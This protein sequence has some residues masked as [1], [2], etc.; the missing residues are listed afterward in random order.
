MEA[1]H[2]RIYRKSLKLYEDLSTCARLHVA[3]LLVKDGRILS[4]GYNGVPSGDHHC[5]DTFIQMDGK[6]YIGPF[7]PPDEFERSR[8]SEKEW[9]EKHH[10]FSE[11]HEIHAEMNCIAYAT[12]NHVDITGCALIV[13][14]SPCIHC[15]KLI[16]SVGIKQV[17]YENE[18]D[19]SASEGINVLKA[20][21][22]SC[23]KL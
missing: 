21:G 18:Y 17:Y 20:H 12:K 6:F 22:V 5:K 2:R 7:G 13:S 8:V 9:K 1:K 23:E 10:E 3:A 11:K 15:A 4:V 19:R 14:I 16:L